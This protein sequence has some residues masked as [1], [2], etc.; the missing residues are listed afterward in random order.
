VK[1]R[2][3]VFDSLCVQDLKKA[4][5]QLC[6]SERMAQERGGHEGEEEWAVYFL[7]KTYIHQNH[8]TN[9]SQVHEDNGIGVGT[10]HSKGQRLVLLHCGS[11][12]GWLAGTTLMWTV[13][14]GKA[15]SGDYHNNVDHAKFLKWFISSSAILI[16]AQLPAHLLSVRFNEQVCKLIKKPSDIVMSKVEH[17]TREGI[18]HVTPEMWKKLILHGEK[19]EEEMWYDDV[20]EYIVEEFDMSSSSSSYI[21]LPCPAWL[22]SCWLSCVHHKKTKKMSR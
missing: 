19:I 17:L 11:S 18:A 14:K 8:A 5:I 10:P 2:G 4:Y 21:I 6:M 13:K 9:W 3:E 20:A 12:Q 1:K 16:V 15:S 22:V 7:D